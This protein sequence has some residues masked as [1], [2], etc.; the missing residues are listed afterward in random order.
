MSS[1]ESTRGPF[2]DG[3]RH[4]EQRSD[5]DEDTRAGTP[6]TNFCT[7]PAFPSILVGSKPYGWVGGRGLWAPHQLSPSILVD[8]KPYG[9]VG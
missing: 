5:D 7:T 2:R 8:S 3:R 1:F 6:S 4:S 9:W